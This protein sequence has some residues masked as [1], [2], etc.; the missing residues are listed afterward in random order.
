MRPGDGTIPEWA[1][2]NAFLPDETSRPLVLGNLV[3]LLLD[4]EVSHAA[5]G[6]RN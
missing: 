6:M 1:L 3:N 4:E 5:A 2:L